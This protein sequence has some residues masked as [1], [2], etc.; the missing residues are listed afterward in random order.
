MADNNKSSS[1]FS[2]KEKEATR[3]RAREQREFKKLPG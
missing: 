2:D 3:E 1:T